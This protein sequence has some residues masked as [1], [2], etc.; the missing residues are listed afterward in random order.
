M[1]FARIRL[2][3]FKSFV[4]AAD[5]RIEPGLTGVVGPNGCG[6]SNI[7]EAMRWVMG[8]ASAK[9]MRGEGMDDVIFA[10]ASGRPARNHAEVTLTIDNTDGA[11]GN[12]P[13]P[14]RNEPVLE[15]S[16]RID[17][18][19][20]STFHRINGR[21]VRARDVQ[22]LFA[23]ASTGANSPAL[24]RRGQISELIAARPQSRRRILEE[25]AGVTGPARPPSRGGAAR[26]RR[27]RQLGAPRRSRP[28]KLESALMASARGAAGGQVQGPG[29]GDPLPAGLPAAPPLAGGARAA[30]ERLGREAE[31][32]R[33]ELEAATRAAGLATTAATAAEGAIKPL[34]DEE[35][36]A[37]AA[38]NRLAIDKDRLD[39]DLDQ[40]R[41]DA[42]RLAG[43][44]ARL[45]SDDA[46]EAAWPT[47]PR[48]WSGWTRP[49][50]RSRPR[51]PPRPN[52][53]P[54]WRRRPGRRRRRD[55][56]RRRGWKPWR[57]LWP[58][59]K[60]SIARLGRESRKLTAGG[61]GPRPRSP[62][63]AR[64]WRRSPPQAKPMK[65]RRITPQSSP[66]SR[67]R[68]RP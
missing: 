53:P 9:A 31:A 1:D 60:R 39:R 19:E 3:G 52:A 68:A 38:L 7:L 43:E 18:G 29:G 67:R 36:V 66:R 26:R 37:T 47:R 22:I 61:T 35:T 54:P 21:E 27:R 50:P 58:T 11:E 51:S 12:A 2:S 4:D 16:R 15:V 30:A 59:P 40:A 45:A 33:A 55:P 6:K 24:V 57:R 23:D 62:K 14:F 34:R 28:R 48:P 46:R 56:K 32:A 49:K 8:A 13:A 63:R 5:F 42:E 65:P 41:A 10:G 20:G 44:L 17:R 64:P 25:A